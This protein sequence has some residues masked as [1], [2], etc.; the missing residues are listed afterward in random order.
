MALVNL[1]INSESEFQAVADLVDMDNLIDYM[2]LHAL[3]EANDWLQ[4]DNAHNWYGARRRANPTNGLPATK[5]VFL[6]WDQVFIN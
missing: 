5:W 6:P 4:A 2:L 3:V 1:G